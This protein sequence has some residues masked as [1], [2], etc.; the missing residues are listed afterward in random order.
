MIQFQSTHESVKVWIIFVTERMIFLDWNTFNDTFNKWFD[1]SFWWSASL[2]EDF[3]VGRKEVSSVKIDI[4]FN[5]GSK[6]GQGFSD[7]GTRRS[8]NWFCFI[9][10]VLNS[11]LIHVRQNVRKFLPRNI[12]RQ[13]R[14]QQKLSWVS[15]YF[16]KLFSSDAVVLVPL[17]AADTFHMLNNF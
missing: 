16:N 9:E 5:T 4:T 1:A 7:I 11:V 3:F 2:V 12:V 10:K 6:I 17:V 14:L 13:K 15:F 8:F